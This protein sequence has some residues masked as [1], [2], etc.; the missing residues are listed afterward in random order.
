MCVVA[1]CVADLD[2]RLAI[3]Y[4]DASKSAMGRLRQQGTA[5][6]PMSL[7]P[8]AGDENDLID[9]ANKWWRDNMK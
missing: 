2:G 8:G 4:N 6:D 7:Q 3:L 5:S 9:K 1:G